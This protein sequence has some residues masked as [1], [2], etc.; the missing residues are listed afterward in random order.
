[1][2]ARPLLVSFSGSLDVCCSGQKIRCAVGDV[3]VATH[4]E[5]DVAIL[6]SVRGSDLQ[7]SIRNNSCA[8]RTLHR[9]GR[10]TNASHA[11]ETRRAWAGA[12]ATPFR[13][14]AAQVA[15]SQRAGDAMARS[16][17]CLVPAGDTF[18]SSRLYSSI[19]AGCLPVI[20]GDPILR[21]AAFASRVNYTAFAVQ[22]AERH[23]VRWPDKLVPFLRHMPVAEVQ[24]RQRAL[25]AARRQILFDV[26]NGT[27]AATHFMELASERC[28]PRM[29]KCGA[30]H[31]SKH[32]APLVRGG[33]TGRS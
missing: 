7:G 32:L 25:A 31:V 24:Q 8:A 3:M 16:V 4:D 12:Y 6:P 27:A 33:E 10:V 13:H 22:V 2:A 28:F 17:F 26:P 1:M 19:G 9:L 29:L 23:F 21:V 20:L 30:F 11:S 5:T 14:S 18:I 15:L